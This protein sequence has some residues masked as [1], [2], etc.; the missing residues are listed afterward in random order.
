MNKLFFAIAIS[1]LMAGTMF[2]SCESAE[3]KEE[4]ARQEVAETEREL[5]E[6]QEEA[7]EAAR[8]VAME[9]EWVVFKRDAEA[10]IAKNEIRIAELRVKLKKPGKVLDEVY[11]KRID[12]LEAEN[13]ELRA[14]IVAYERKDSDW[15]EFKREFNHD[16]NQIGK[17]LEDLGKDNKN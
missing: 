12:T 9:E 13:R 16:M 4:K 17:A 11:A 10:Q 8:K 7:N 2:T 6:A 15:E 1:I 5:R 14:R 3:Q